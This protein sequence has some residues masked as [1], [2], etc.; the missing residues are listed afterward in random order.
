MKTQSSLLLVLIL[1]TF[2]SQVKTVSTV[3]SNLIK[4]KQARG[5]EDDYWGQNYDQNQ[6][7]AQRER[8]AELKP[9][10]ESDQ[11]DIEHNSLPRPGGTGGVSRR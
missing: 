9:K 3:N 4:L 10:V 8:I 5:G 2:D 1:H 6:N 7:C 11:G